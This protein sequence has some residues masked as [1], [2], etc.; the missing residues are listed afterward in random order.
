MEEEIGT[1]ARADV[2]L[3]FNIQELPPTTGVSAGGETIAEKIERESNILYGATLR[4][5]ALLGR[6]VVLPKN[7]LGLEIQSKVGKEMKVENTF[8]E[9]HLWNHDFPVSRN[10]NCLG[11]V[12]DLM[13]VS[14]AVFDS[15]DD[16]E[17][18]F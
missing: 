4:G 11:N 16:E 12:A 15:E 14:R 6:K 8:R 2:N 9:I 1:S 7:V 5:R 17:G 3:Y 18:G 13:D 10:D